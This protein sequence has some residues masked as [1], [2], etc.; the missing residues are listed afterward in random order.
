MRQALLTAAAVY[1]LF[2]STVYVGVMWALHFFFYPSWKSMR[3]DSVQDHFII[4]TSAATRFFLVVVP[5]MFLTGLALV[6][7]E[8]GDWGAPF[9]AAVIAFLGISGSTYVGWIHIIP[10]NRRIKAGV[11]DEATLSHLLQRWMFLND[12][13]LLT[14]TV[15]WGATVWYFVAKGNLVDAL[16]H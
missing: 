6:I 8:I 14:T 2:G 1:F 11:A 4:P 3:L 13:R 12:V 16:K 15:M 5:I 9:W 10:I 7:N